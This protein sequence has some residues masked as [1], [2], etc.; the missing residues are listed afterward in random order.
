MAIRVVLVNNPGSELDS[1]R[2]IVDAEKDM[3]VVAEAGDGCSAV[4]LAI[5]MRP[6]V[7]VM[8]MLLPG[9]NCFEATRKIKEEHNEARI[10]VLGNYTDDFIIEQA[11][12]AGASR[13]L[14]RKKARHELPDAIRTSLVNE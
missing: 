5:E 11:L 8:G 9:M 7:I 10:V 14:L 1:L 3:D 13:Y 12:D 6:E 2:D 4:R